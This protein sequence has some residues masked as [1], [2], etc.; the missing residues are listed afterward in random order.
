MRK[1][2]LALVLLSTLG[3]VGCSSSGSSFNQADSAATPNN[4]GS[5]TQEESP[6]AD[7][8]K[9]DSPK[10]DS[11][12][13][14]SP[15]ADS[16]ETDSP[17]ADSP[18]TDSPKADSPETDSPKADSPETDSP[19]MDSPD[20]GHPKEDPTNEEPVDNTA[21]KLAW[22]KV[23]YVP[24][25]K[26]GDM[27]DPIIPTDSADSTVVAT[28]MNGPHQFKASAD[29]SAASLL[30]EYEAAGNVLINSN[31][32]DPTK[33]NTVTLTDDNGA[34][35]GKYQ[36]VNQEYSSYGLFMPEN[37]FS[38]GNP[39]YRVEALS[40]Y[41]ANPTT[42]DQFNAQTGK[43][44]YQGK[45]LGYLDGPNGETPKKE[46]VANI[47]LDVDFAERLISGVVKG[48][49]RFDNFLSSNWRYKDD[50]GNITP[51][52]KELNKVDL[53]LKPTKIRE[54]GNGY[55][56]FGGLP[57]RQSEYGWSVADLE[58]V[59]VHDGD[60]E[61]TVANGQFGGIFAGPNAEEVVGQI[62]GGDER[63]SFGATRQ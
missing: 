46:A 17:K 54:L 9:A 18:E 41:V 1:K 36:F 29:A 58:Q 27:F 52:G 4:P 28:Y 44:Q 19:E 57:K 33:V 56:G 20:A 5:A 21:E 49:E 47:H 14:E 2:T 7:S 48:E 42:V 37:H 51:R 53:I 3:I 13:T 22:R 55:V 62:G 34:V 43:A 50:D 24:S 8:P 61:V 25:H 6:K 63:L 32:V 26:G 11:P 40:F 16:P 35:L 10:A 31:V 30:K 59:V 15:K 38:Y 39:D 45:V 12:E 23:N 60:K